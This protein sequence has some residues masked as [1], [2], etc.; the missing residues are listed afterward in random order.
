MQSFKK[1]CQCVVA[2]AN[3]YAHEI[4]NT[5]PHVFA[6]H[7]C[8]GATQRKQFFWCRRRVDRSFQAARHDQVMGTHAHRELLHRQRVAPCRQHPFVKPSRDTAHDDR[9]CETRAEPCGACIQT[10]HSA[11]HL[12]CKVD[13]AFDDSEP[14][15]CEMQIEKL[16]SKR[17]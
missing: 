6:P 8:A 16:R 7:G 13:V 3:V 10:K 4:P 9:Q 1:R 17:P 5:G 2:L 15:F 12:D 11:P 14:I